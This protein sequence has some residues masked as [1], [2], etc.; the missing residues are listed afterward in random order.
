MTRGD[1]ALWQGEVERA[2]PLWQRA[3]VVRSQLGDRRGVAGSL[4]RL[5]WGLAA[6]DLFELAAWLFGAAEAQH[7]L[8][9]IV[10]RNDE[11]LDHEHLVVMTRQQLGQAFARVFSAG[12]ASGVDEAVI[13][14]V[15]GTTPAS[16]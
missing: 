4:E 3:L 7:K 16:N 13:R 8:L 1:H 5:A 11:K 6:S 12:N 2:V 14:A 10:L 9:G 15:E